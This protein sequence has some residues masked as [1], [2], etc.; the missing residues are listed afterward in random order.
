MSLLGW[1]S[2]VEDDR[3]RPCGLGFS[4]RV[5]V[6]TDPARRAVLQKGQAALE[7]R[8]SLRDT[9]I[10][11]T[12]A[13]VFVILAF[14]GIVPIAAFSWHRVQIPVV[15]FVLSPLGIGVTAAAIGAFIQWRRARAMRG[16]MALRVVLSGGLCPSCGYDLLD[17]PEDSE[18]LVVCPECSAAWR[19]GRID[20]SRRMAGESATSLGAQIEEADRQG[21]SVLVA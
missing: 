18:G 20:R 8:Q 17:L 13:I 2:R 12:I 9:P 14:L 16:P 7:Y 5:G 10:C 4:E 11:S 15:I 6:A 3:G 19:S 21:Q 1:T